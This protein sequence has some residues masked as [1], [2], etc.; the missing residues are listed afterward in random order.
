MPTRPWL[1]ALI[2]SVVA[3]AGFSQM[4]DGRY[5]YMSMP[6]GAQTEG[7]SGRGILIFDVDRGYR[8]VKRIDV[9]AF[10]EGLRGFTGSQASHCIYYSTTNHLLGCFDLETEKVV[11]EKRYPLGCD[12]SSITMDG[13]KIYVPTGWWYAGQDGGF[14]V[15]RAEDGELLKQIPVGP[16]AHNSIVSLDGRFAYL[17][18]R[19]KLTVFDMSYVDKFRDDFLH[20]IENKTATCHP[21]VTV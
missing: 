1:V 17:G 10:Q 15:V 11:W 3:S 13:R 4:Q 20:H 6:D 7:K 14:L 18:T 5:L 8:F 19:T 21:Q 9:P 16:Q 12:R 2:L